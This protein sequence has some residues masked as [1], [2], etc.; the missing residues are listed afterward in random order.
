MMVVVVV[1]RWCDKHF[2][3]TVERPAA[4]SSIVGGWRGHAP[5]A[6]LVTIVMRRFRISSASRL[7]SAFLIFSGGANCQDCDCMLRVQNIVGVA[8]Q[9]DVANRTD[10][11]QISLTPC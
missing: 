7:S 6:C 8:N 3:F 9:H 4:V 1:G 2:D 5:G 11:R 10:R